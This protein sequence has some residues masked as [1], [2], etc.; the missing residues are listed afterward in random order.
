[1]ERDL[2]WRADKPLSAYVRLARALGRVVS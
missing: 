1:M 2:H